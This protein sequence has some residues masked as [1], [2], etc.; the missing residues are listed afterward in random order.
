MRILV[1]MDGVIADFEAG[2]LREWQRQY[3]ERGFIPLDQRTTFY[4]REQYPASVF[5][6]VVNLQAAPGFFRALDPIP[7]S[8]DALREMDALKIEVFICSGPFTFYRTCLLEKYEWVEQHLGAD[9]V[10][11]IIL[12][13]DKT[14]IQADVLIDDKPEIEGVENPPC[15]EHVIFDA[16]YNRVSN[17]KRRVNWENWKTVLL[18]AD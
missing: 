7:G 4:I 2:F 10:K 17:G 16:P 6:D 3:P 18:G 5:I 14:L 15:W 8:I 1:D 11:R 9:W 13:K 12:T